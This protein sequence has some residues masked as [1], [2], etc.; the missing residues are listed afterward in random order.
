MDDSTVAGALVDEGAV[1]GIDLNAAVTIG[2]DAHR[3]TSV[4][5]DEKAA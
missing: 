4:T 2:G 1:R 3:P 5:A